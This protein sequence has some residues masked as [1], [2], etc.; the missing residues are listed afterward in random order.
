MKQETSIQMT[1]ETIPS[2]EFCMLQPAAFPVPLL[3]EW[4]CTSVLCQS[5]Q[6]CSKTHPK[7]RV[8]SCTKRGSVS[9]KRSIFEGVSRTSGWWAQSGVPPARHEEPPSILFAEAMC[10][11]FWGRKS[12]RNV[13][14]GR[15]V[16]R[17][18]CCFVVSGHVPG[19]SS[20]LTC[21]LY[22]VGTGLET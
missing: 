17:A 21:I 5:A 3:F 7:A 2:L 22:T 6:P 16:Y 8:D 18:G 20:F 10:Y 19:I 12:L 4:N 14:P 9:Q 13:G 15:V 1:T 11:V